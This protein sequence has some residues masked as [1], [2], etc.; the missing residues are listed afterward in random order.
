MAMRFGRAAIAALMVAALGAAGCGRSGESETTAGEAGSPGI[1]DTEIKLGGTFPY[2]GPASAYATLAK[3]MRAHF[4]MV[5]EAGGV[6]G[7]RITFETLDDG[8]DPTRG[9]QATRR[10]VERDGVF[11]IFGTGGT[12]V[13]VA[14]MDY[15]NDREVPQAFVT[16]GVS[17]FGADPERFPWSI[18]FAP[19]YVT[20]GRIYAS[21][22]KREHPDAKVGILYQNDALG[23]DYLAGFEPALE[24]SGVRVLDKQSYE[25]TDPSVASQVSRLKSAGADTLV[26][27]TTPKF[28]AQAIAEKHDLGWDPTVVL[29][30]I[31]SSPG[32]TL[33]PAG[34]DA[35]RGL[36]TAAYYK[37]PNNPRFSGDADVKAYLD[38]MR[39][40]APD[41]AV[42]D[43]FALI[44]WAETATL[45][46]TL[47]QM[48]EP[49]RES[50]MAAARDLDVASA[51]LLP[52][53]R[54]TTGPGDGFPL[55]A[56]QIARFDG[57]AYDLEGE[58]IEGTAR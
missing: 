23:K 38:A 6:D 27:F 50:F 11:A 47:K 20:E 49:T 58:I 46:E 37:D 16:S 9:L 34:L 54:A 21:W 29:D 4:A 13:S 42:D 8:Y 40:W 41:V 56:M 14:T 48:E 32:Q 25:V 22:L 55:Q 53:I 35:A 44:A 1:T 24:G 28:A 36:V 7:R 39:R 18:G 12:P 51:M 31:S 2:S 3:S 26:L 45:I 19:D 17:L 43:P 15:L 30:S 33:E 52:G 5:N 57:R 10:L